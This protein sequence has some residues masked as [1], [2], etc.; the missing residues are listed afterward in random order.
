MKIMCSLNVTTLFTKDPTM[1][2]SF[3]GSKSLFSSWSEWSI[4]LTRSSECSLDCCNKVGPDPSWSRSVYKMHMI[5][6]T[7]SLVVTSDKI[8]SCSVYTQ[9]AYLCAA[10]VWSHANT[11]SAEIRLLRIHRTS[12]DFI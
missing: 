5:Q 1:T 9:Q 4:A 7:S 12:I 11:R 2:L 10:R 6:V 8:N 3:V